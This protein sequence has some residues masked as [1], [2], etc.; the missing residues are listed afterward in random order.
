MGQSAWKKYGRSR[1]ELG[2]ATMA[3]VLSGGLL[4]AGTARA[5]DA[6]DKL[7][8]QIDALQKQITD[9]KAHPVG[10]SMPSL[11]ADDGT[12]TWRGVTLYG[13]IDVGVSGQTHGSGYNPDFVTGSGEL[14]QK[15]GGGAKWLV[16]PGGMEQNKIGLKGRE[17]VMDGLDVVFKLE[18]GF[19]PVSGNLS[20]SQKSQID[21]NGNKTLANTTTNGDSSRAGQPFE[22]AAFAGLS[23]GTY[24]T[25][26]FG[27]QT[28]PLADNVTAYDPQTTSYAFSPIEWSGF[29]AGAGNT[30]TARL[31]DSIKYAVA[32]GPVRFTGIYQFAGNT[33]S[34]GGD[35][36]YQADLGLDYGRLSLD[37]LYAVK[38]D[39]INTATNPNATAA[40]GNL[41]LLNA[42]VS[43][44]R[45]FAF[46]A[47]YDLN[48]V[49][50]M[51]GYEHITFNN[52]KTT[53]SGSAVALSGYGYGTLSQTNYSTAES[54]HVLW[55]GARWAIQPDLTL[56]AA[57]YMYIQDNWSGVDNGVCVAN[58]N[59]G[60]C[61]GTEKMVS[62]SLDYQMTKRFD[63]Y[64]GV[65]Y[66]RVDDGLYSGYLHNNTLSPAAG[67]RFKF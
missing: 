19:N 21:N 13:T 61:A 53:L 12:L 29:T 11:L 36:A 42:T 31:D 25:L 37:G 47:K 28:T 55:T 34:Y 6:T 65:M 62:V 18:T 20:S 22:G 51:G 27:R 17:N 14:L 10:A 43:D 33:N 9:M 46:F 54:F 3:L 30:E 67:L 5:D 39:G 7:Q 26:T 44:T 23:S 40:A 41:T 1:R 60:K 16:T 63:V 45:A 52:P 66:S 24:G 8:A 35:D 32:Y 59:T 2:V 64:G 38:H 4:S 56:A 48:P 57:Y 50:I 15:N 58:G 49:K